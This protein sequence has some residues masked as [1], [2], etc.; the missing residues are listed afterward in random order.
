MIFPFKAFRI[1]VDIFYSI[2]DINNLYIFLFFLALSCQGV[3]NFI[4]LF[5]EPALAL[6]ICSLI[7]FLCHLYLLLYLLVPPIYY[8]KALNFS[9]ITALANSH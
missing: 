1:C 4:N 7:C 5:I 8:I 6:L 2:A 9:L 3:I